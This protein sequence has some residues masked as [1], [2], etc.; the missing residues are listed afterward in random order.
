MSRGQ[1]PRVEKQ[2]DDVRLD[3]VQLAL[4]LRYMLLKIYFHFIR[5][6]VLKIIQTIRKYKFTSTFLE[7]NFLNK[8]KKKAP[9]SRIHSPEFP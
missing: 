3:F 4:A 9:L 1:G 8:Q 6:Y 7:Q 2:T 5:I